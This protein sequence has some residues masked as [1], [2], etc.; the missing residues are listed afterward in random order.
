M[1]TRGFATEIKVGI[2][3]AVGL[4]ALATGILIIDGN[5]FAAKAQEFY[6]VLDNVAGVAARTGVRVSGVQIGEVSEVELLPKGAKVNF[7]VDPKVVIPKGSFIELRS[8]GILGDVFLEIVRD[9]NNKEALQSGDMIPKVKEQNDLNS[10]MS[11]IGS[12]AKNI[13]TVSHTLALVLGNEEGQASL[14]NIIRNIE[15]VT[16]DARELV[17]G[18]RKNV[19]AAIQGMR[20]VAERLAL[21]L[22]KN[23]GRID[24]VLASIDSA[25]SDFKVFAGELRRMVS[26]EN[27]GKLEE[28]LTA[29]DDSMS[30]IRETSSKVKLVADKIER[31]E[32]TIGALLSKDDTINEVNSTLRNVQ[33]FLRPA[34]QL[35]VDVDY[36]GEYRGKT[37]SGSVGTTGNHF[38]VRLST[39]PDRFY[40]LGLTDS[41]TSRHVSAIETETNVD[42]NKTT[43]TRTE[44]VS[45]DVNRIRIN[46]QFA[47]RFSNVGVRFGFFESYAGIAGDLYLFSDRFQ[48][49]VEVF[50]FKNE[51][52]RPGVATTG[53][54]PR[55]KG[56]G[57]VFVTSNIYVTGGV[58]A[59]NN[60][61]ATRQGSET[62]APKPLPFV[63]AGLRFTDDDLRAVIGAATLAR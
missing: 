56:Y 7:T 44:K 38:N 45:A 23:D 6:T 61:N 32:G 41:P 36:K 63:G 49:A 16:T 52:T 48:G 26:G 4:G 59:I 13:Q 3:T 53:F 10:L 14:R 33:E 60:L 40:L 31:G 1:L 43:V 19:A 27:Q 62:V 25:S 28:I 57:N 8:R 46:A 20:T 24:S 30:N 11:S 18:E 17:Y 9:E 58:D 51:S 12:I 2:F 39:R 21:M 37:A 5:P 22:E 35:K 29:L 34:T 54:S 55:V 50:D 15:Q 47:K 42:G